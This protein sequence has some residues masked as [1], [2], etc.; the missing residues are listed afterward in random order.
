MRIERDIKLDYADVLFRPKR[1]TMGSRKEV[2]LHRTYTFRNS[3]KTYSGLPIMAANMDGVGTFGMALPLAKNGMF[4]CLAKSYEPAEIWDWFN[5]NPNK[6]DLAQTI[7]VSTGITDI[8][9]ERV[10]ATLKL[11]RAIDYVCIDVANGYSERFID[12]VKRFREEYPNITIIAGNVVTPDITEELILNGADVALL[13]LDQVVFVLLVLRLALV[14]L[15]YRLSL[16]VLMRRMV[17]ADILSLTVVVL[18]LVML[19]RHLEPEQTL[20]CSGVCLQE[21]IKAGV[22]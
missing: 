12:F 1:S 8:D 4:T 15:S 5:N 14:I 11:N 13:E 2:D 22:R 18:A 17:W 6:D 20:S 3:G 10:Q 21:L 9:F 7:A 19:P 16:N